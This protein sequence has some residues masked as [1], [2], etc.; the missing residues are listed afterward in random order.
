MALGDKV[1]GGRIIGPWP[2]EA[3]DE[4]NPL[5]P[6][7]IMPTTDFRDVFA[8]VLRSTHALSDAE[9]K[10]VFPSAEMKSVGLMS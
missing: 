4:S 6:G 10:L 2:T 5:G 8:E 7:G 1:K 9:A 3:T